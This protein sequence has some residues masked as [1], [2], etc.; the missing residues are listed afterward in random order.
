MST[1]KDIKLLIESTLNYI[2]NNDYL[3]NEFNQTR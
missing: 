1:K 2:N 3:K